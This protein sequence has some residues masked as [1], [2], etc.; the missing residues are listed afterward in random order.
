MKISELP[1]LPKTIFRFLVILVVT[2]ALA[3]G[4][5][6]TAADNS[7]RKVRYYQLILDEVSTQIGAENLSAIQDIVYEREKANISSW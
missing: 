2:L 7:E 3:A 1:A 5:F 6:Y 4:Y